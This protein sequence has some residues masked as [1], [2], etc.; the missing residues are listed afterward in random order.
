[1]RVLLVFTLLI[2]AVLV[3]PSFVN[4]DSY[5]EPL[6]SQINKHTNLRIAIDGDIKLSLLPRPHFSISQVSVKNESQTKNEEPFVKLK[7]LSFSVDFLPLLRKKIS[8]R[9]VELIEPVISVNKQ[10]EYTKK[11]VSISVNLSKQSRDDSSNESEKKIPQQSNKQKNEES[12]ALSLNITK[13]S[14]IDGS[15]A[16]TDSKTKKR[17]EIKAINI[18]GGF[19][20]TNGFDMQASANIDGMQA[21]GSIKSGAFVDGL[22]SS[23]DAKFTLAQDKGIQG[24]VTLLGAQKDGV[25]TIKATSDA[26]KL[27]MQV[28]IGAQTIDFAKGI[29]FNID[30]TMRDKIVTISALKAKLADITVSGKGTY[31]TEKSTGSLGISLI[32][33]ILNAAGT[34]GID[35]SQAKP[36]LIV[37]LA[38]PKVDDKAWNKSEKSN[39]NTDA[40]ANTESAQKSSQEH[41]S[42]DPINLNALQSVNAD[43]TLAIDRLSLNDIDAAKVKL[44]LILSNGVATIKQLSANVFDGS[45]TLTGTL[46]SKSGQLATDAKLA[47]MNVLKLPGVEG[48]ALKAGT[49]NLSALITTRVTSMYAIINHLNGTAH[50][51]VTKG[52]VEGVDIKQFMID[53]K[54]TKDLSGLSKLK[55][56]FDRKA[57][58]AFNYVRGDV[59]LTNGV[60]NTRNFEIDM[61]EGMIKSA[62]TVDLPKWV[63]A[64]NSNL[65]VRDAKN[66]PSFAVNITGPIDQPSFAL[67]MDQL[68]KAL[69]QLATNQLADRAKDTVK[70]KVAEQLG[71]AVK[72]EIADK[73][74]GEAAKAIG[75]LLPGLLR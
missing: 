49:L 21:K 72:G 11:S 1:M 28:Q 47:S 74:G 68:Q 4:W 50:L 63:L 13:A 37:D 17:T 2:V 27:P 30:T 31:D 9:S 73:L 10:T 54:T 66:I 6:L 7:Q 55:A 59:T 65:T 33:N 46:D 64:L 29:Q 75:K 5:K 14:V 61:N 57:D 20:F 67:D 42:K 52:I 34:V 16:L 25:F 56:S 48:S 69:L 53:L 26:I 15:V 58:M 36:M 62:G 40:K 12:D 51:D 3:I 32:S 22:P 70:K 23:L 71:G 38:L 35:L 18:S 43:V 45:A 39:A 41:W 44:R 8:I 24:V 19:S 60:A